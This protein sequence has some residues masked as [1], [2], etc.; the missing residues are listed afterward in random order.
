MSST[1]LDSIKRKLNLVPAWRFREYAKRFADVWL[2]RAKEKHRYASE[3]TQEFSEAPR[4]LNIFPFGG[5][6]EDM[7]FIEPSLSFENSYIIWSGGVAHL[8]DVEELQRAL[9]ADEGLAESYL[10]QFRSTNTVDMDMDTPNLGIVL[11]SIRN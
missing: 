5:N 8:C 9:D 2:R 7:M 10:R 3:E 6:D 4:L 1:T 11:L